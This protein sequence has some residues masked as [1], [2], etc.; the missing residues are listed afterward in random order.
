MQN[1][2]RKTHTLVLRFR[3]DRELAFSYPEATVYETLEH[4]IEVER[5]GFDLTEWLFVFLNACTHIS[6]EEF[7]QLA[8][9]LREI[10]ER[11]LSTRFCG[12]FDRRSESTARYAPFASYIT[13]AAK[14]LGTDPLTLM[15]RYTFGQLSAFME[16][17]VWNLNE[18]SEEGRRTNSRIRIEHAQ[19]SGELDRDLA[20][21]REAETR[22]NALRESTHT[23]PTI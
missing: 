10:H 22:A 19:A 20:I 6:H 23:N 1:L 2:I 9:S 18:Q 13:D 11:V 8:G 4:I 14:H 16:G 5:E 17:I 12:A 7:A 21:A 15:E 3:N